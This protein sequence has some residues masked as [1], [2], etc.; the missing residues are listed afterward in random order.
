[1][2]NI[3]IIILVLFLYFFLV[4]PQINKMHSPDEVNSLVSGLNLSAGRPAFLYSPPL[5]PALLSATIKFLGFNDMSTRLI[6]IISVILSCAGAFL[7]SKKVAGNRGNFFW[8][9]FVS[10]L[11]LYI[12]PMIVQGSLI[13]D[14]DNTIMVPNIVVFYL[15]F[16]DIRAGK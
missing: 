7:I 11:I 15:F 1:M 14:I 3:F 2:K 6:G 8:V 12:H 16:D 13:C 5:Y 4:F 9:L 10:I